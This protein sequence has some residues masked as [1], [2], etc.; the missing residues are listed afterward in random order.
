MRFGNARSIRS[1]KRSL[2]ISRENKMNAQ[3]IVST[4]TDLVSRELSNK[5][6]SP[7]TSQERQMAEYLADPVKLMV[8]G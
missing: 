3:N 7:V 1:V 4:L 6:P 8:S 2:I 5:E